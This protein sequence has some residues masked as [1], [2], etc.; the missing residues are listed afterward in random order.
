MMAPIPKFCAPC[1]YRFAC[2]AS[3]GKALQEAEGWMLVISKD[4]KAYLST[5]KNVDIRK[6]LCVKVDPDGREPTVF[7]NKLIGR[8]V[9]YDKTFVDLY[10]RL[11]KI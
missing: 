4:Y 11:Y 7:D 1:E 5:R 9:I 2:P 10:R 3:P 6:C 8:D